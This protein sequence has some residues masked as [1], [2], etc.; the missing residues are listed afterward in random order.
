MNPTGVETPNWNRTASLR[1]DVV[2]FG[3]KK[4][5]AQ[6]PPLLDPKDSFKPV[7]KE[8]S[9]YTLVRFGATAPSLDASPVSPAKEVPPTTEDDKPKTFWQ[10]LKALKNFF[11]ADNAKVIA[12]IT[13]KHVLPLAFG[14]TSF[15]SFPFGLIIG[16]VGI[17]PT[18]LMGRLGSKLLDSVREKHDKGEAK[19]HGTLASAIKIEGSKTVDDFMKNF[20]TLVDDV[21]D[22]NRV[23][24]LGTLKNV[25]KL[26]P[27]EGIGLYLK[28]YSFIWAM[29]HHEVAQAETPGDAAVA[30][31][32]G[33]ARG[34]VY[35]KVLPWLGTLVEKGSSALPFPLKWAGW[36]VGEG[37][38]NFGVIELLR[39]WATG[40]LNLNTNPNG[41]VQAT[42][43]S[44]DK[45]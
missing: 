22:V 21:L 27:T 32:K 25:L 29:V 23:P 20:N 10:N 14:L 1:G 33:A 6:N 2:Q 19:L 8:E 34:F 36:L 35:H 11:N 15:L 7:G 40:N 42:A 4:K 31:V 45:A 17:I 18:Y 30:G 13:L 24:W 41:P 28:K 37:I 12:G 43:P 39:D 16:V 3:R 38:K 9:L 5:A 44:L 26:N